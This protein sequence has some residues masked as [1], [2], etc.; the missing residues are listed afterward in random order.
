M[1]ACV[2]HCFLQGASVSDI[3]VQVCV[4]AFDLIFFN[5]KVRRLCTVTVG[6]M[7]VLGDQLIGADEC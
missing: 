5:G 4:F 1:V 7:T 6:G 2:N 3:Q